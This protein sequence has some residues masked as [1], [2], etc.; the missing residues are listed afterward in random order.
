MPVDQGSV[1]NRRARWDPNGGQWDQLLK[2]FLE[3]VDAKVWLRYPEVIKGS[4]VDKKKI[5][6]H[7]RFVEKL[8]HFQPNLC[9]NFL[10][11]VKLFTYVHQEKIVEAD[12]ELDWARTM[13]ARLRVM[14][15]HI[16][17]ARKKCPKWLAGFRFAAYGKKKVLF[18]EDVEEECC[19]QNNSFD[20]DPLE[21]DEEGEEEDLC[22]DTLVDTVDYTVTE[23]EIED[24]NTFETAATAAAT[25]SASSGQGD[26][27]ITKPCRKLGS[28]VSRKPAAAAPVASG[29]FFGYDAELEK[30]WRQPNTGGE[31]EYALELVA[32][33]GADACDP[34]YGVF[35]DGTKTEN[36]ALSV[37]DLHRLAAVGVGQKKTKEFGCLP[38]G[39]DEDST[40]KVKKKTRLGKTLIGLLVGDS[41][42]LQLVV[43]NYFES[44][45]AGMQFMENMAAD[46]ADGKIAVEDLV[47]ERKKR[48]GAIAGKEKFCG[49]I[50]LLIFPL[51]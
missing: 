18:S 23:T 30:F 28:V 3:H 49:I 11:L 16:T 34:T 45:D 7:K 50:G 21:E 35:Q 8:S 39:G 43:P 33:P 36:P 46:L 10:D 5:V 20:G 15:R 17:Q 9:F 41:Q 22:Y 13:S 19:E 27:D 42:K 31:K 24:E 29:F 32:L 44:D 48:L 4:R 40:I 47:A 6:P 25:A 37:A 12:Q 51:K 2:L 14:L 1:I 38:G 26:Q